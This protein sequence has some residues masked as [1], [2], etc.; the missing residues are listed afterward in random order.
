L[1]LILYIA[2][3]VMHISYIYLPTYVFS[4][5]VKRPL[6]WYFV[7]LLADLYLETNNIH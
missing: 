7:F 4:S 5:G 2:S 1:I 3:N 6:S